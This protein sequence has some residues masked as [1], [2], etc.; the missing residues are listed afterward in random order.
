MSLR[1]RGGAPAVLTA[2]PAASGATPKRYA[3]SRTS[4]TTSVA[5]SGASPVITTSIK[6]VDKAGHV[7]TEGCFGVVASASGNT[8]KVG[9]NPF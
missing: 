1:S 2:A 8:S 4:P 3:P 7:K 6:C 5:T 9:P